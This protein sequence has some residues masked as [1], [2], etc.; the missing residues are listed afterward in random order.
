MWILDRVFK[1]TNF[2]KF[3]NTKTQKNL[4]LFGFTGQKKCNAT[5]ERL[6]DHI[7]DY[8]FYRQ[9]IVLFPE[10]VF[11]ANKDVRLANDMPR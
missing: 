2:G 6:R 11:F 5:I 3:Q 10:G 7:R 9:W 8:I 1:F 4:P